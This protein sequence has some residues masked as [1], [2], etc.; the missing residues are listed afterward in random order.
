MLIIVKNDAI[1]V[2]N[3][4][5][6]PSKCLVPPERLKDIH[7]MESECEPAVRCQVLDPYDEP[8]GVL[9]DAE[10]RLVIGD[11]TSTFWTYLILRFVISFT[12]KYNFNK[13]NKFNNNVVQTN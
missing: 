8:D 2:I 3:F 7:K 1:I 10:C 12:T 13:W 5:A 9:A 4:P 11:P 6:G